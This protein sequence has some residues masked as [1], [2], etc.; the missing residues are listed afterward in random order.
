MRFARKN[1][2]R[3]LTDYAFVK[4][5]ARKADCS[6]FVVYVKGVADCS[7]LGIIATKNLGGSAGRNYAKRVFRAIFREV[8]ENRTEKLA[9]VVYVRR[10]FLKFSYAKLKENFEKGIERAV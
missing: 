5:G 9:V 6:A 1:R 10:A 3:T 7:R 4:N 2:V 8:F